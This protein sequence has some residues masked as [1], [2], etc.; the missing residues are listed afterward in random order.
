MS[1]V[2][3]QELGIPEPKY[4]LG[5]NATS[6]GSMTGRML[7]QIEKILLKEKPDYVLVYGDTNST[8]AGALAASKLHVPESFARLTRTFDF[9]IMG[10]IFRFRT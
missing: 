9:N 7:E 6:H 10:K 4:N 1:E 5:V 8:L 3:F 2:F